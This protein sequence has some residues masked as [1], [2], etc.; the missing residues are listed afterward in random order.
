MPHAPEKLVGLFVVVVD[1]FAVTPAVRGE[2]ERH[3]K[4]FFA[5]RRHELHEADN[6]PSVRTQT[7]GTVRRIQET[8]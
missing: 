2:V 1:P 5:I 6:R 3:D 8:R 7:E 4:V